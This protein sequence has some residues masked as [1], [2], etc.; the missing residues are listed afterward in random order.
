MSTGQ[1]FRVDVTAMHG[2]IL[3]VYDVTGALKN[4]KYMYIGAFN[5]GLFLLVKNEAALGG[6]VKAAIA[7][8]SQYTTPAGC[9][10]YGLVTG[11]GAD[12]VAAAAEAVSF[13][14]WHN[15][16]PT[17]GHT[18]ISNLGNRGINRGDAG[19]VL[20]N[21]SGIA[22]YQTLP[23]PLPHLVKGVGTIN[24]WGLIQTHTVEV[25]SD[26]E[27]N[28]AAKAL[29]LFPAPVDF[30]TTLWDWAVVDNVVAM[31]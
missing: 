19:C 27:A 30:D 1:R 20:A 11:S 21:N 8:L 23:A 13:A 14:V 16:Y 17:P 3:P 7:T 26:S 9:S 2:K 12:A 29:L 10:N 25:N 31:T 24:P 18:G 15:L 5:T 28:A 4:K 6:A 22:I